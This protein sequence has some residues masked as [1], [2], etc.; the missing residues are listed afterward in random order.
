MTQNRE[1]GA[2]AA[3]FGHEAAALIGKKIGA[4]KLTRNSNEF[5]LNG[6]RVTIR[7]ARQGNHQVGVLYDMLERVQ[8]VIGAFE[9]VPNEFELL[10]LAPEVFHA[11]MR[12]SNTGDGRVGL[13]RKKVFD[14][15]GQFVAT[16]KILPEDLKPAEGQ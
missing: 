8:S 3:R 13:V 14:E 16:V 12:D 15:K 10:S 1:T 5:E 9:I 2:E 7:T 11:E 6:Q 4:K